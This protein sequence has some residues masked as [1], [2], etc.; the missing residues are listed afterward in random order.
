MTEWGEVDRAEVFDAA[1]DVEDDVA[2]VLMMAF[3]ACEECG[4]TIGCKWTPEDGA[5]APKTCAEHQ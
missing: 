1:G 2:P 4:R 3:R 5:A